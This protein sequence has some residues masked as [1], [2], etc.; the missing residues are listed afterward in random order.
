MEIMNTSVEELRKAVE[1]LIVSYESQVAII[2]SA[3]NTSHGILDTFKKE[4]V[5]VNN[6]LEESLA[7]NASLRRKDFDTMM[8]DFNLYQEER[9]EEIKRKIDAFLKQQRKLAPKLKALLEGVNSDDTNNSKAIISDIQRRQAEATREVSE[10]IRSFQEEHEQFI[11]E[12]GKIL[13]STTSLSVAD[14][15]NWLGQAQPYKN[16]MTTMTGKMAGKQINIL[17]TIGRG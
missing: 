6:R 11:T 2:G 14:F 9:E 3:I 4:R 1:R 8:R 16:A 5:A 7:K 15:K 10:A 13:T 12:A 17:N